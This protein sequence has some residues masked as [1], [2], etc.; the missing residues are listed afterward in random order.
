MTKKTILVVDD[1]P[2]IVEM[3][4]TFLTLKG[5][6]VLG[7]YTGEG[8]LA[9]IYSEK[10]DAVLLDLM[11]PDI[12]GFEVCQRLRETD[13]FAQLPVLIIS[14]RTDS[15]SKARAENAGADAY[16]TKPIAM[17]RLIAELEQRLEQAEA[18]RDNASGAGN[19][20]SPPDT[21]PAS[22]TSPAT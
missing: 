20:P 21:P 9:M 4:T 3:M 7:A 14:A 11:L 6:D 13:E 5:Y 18:R 10:P 12:E 16:F 17:P 1:E 19:A 8:G 2:H 15:A 22:P